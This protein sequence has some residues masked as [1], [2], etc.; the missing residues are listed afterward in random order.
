MAAARKA[1]LCVFGVC[2][3]SCFILCLIAA[4]AFVGLTVFR[5]DDLDAIVQEQI[6]KVTSL[7]VPSVA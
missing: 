3:S 1:K 2:S 4:G 7:L 5:Q 6:D